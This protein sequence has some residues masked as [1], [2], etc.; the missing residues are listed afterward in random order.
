MFYD[1]R[2][3]ASQIQTCLSDS[4]AHEDCMS[5]TGLS[6]VK[7]YS[8]LISLCTTAGAGEHIYF[9][10]ACCVSRINQRDMGNVM[11]QQSVLK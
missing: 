4:A 5:K 3:N 1:F 2:N 6:F 10:R 11:H 9:W 8:D 7:I